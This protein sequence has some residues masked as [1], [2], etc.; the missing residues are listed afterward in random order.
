[1]NSIE[2]FGIAF[3]P[4]PDAMIDTNPMKLK[5]PWKDGYV[6]DFHSLKSTPTSDPYHPFN[7]E[8]TPMGELLYRLK[9][10][11]NLKAVA[12]TVEAAGDFVMNKWQPPVEVV[13]P[14][15]PSASR[16]VQ[17]VMTISRELGLALGLQVCEDAIEK[18]KTTSQMKNVAVWE[19]QEI[20]HDAIQAGI[21]TVDG[22]SVLLVDDLIESGTTLRR[23]TE[24][25]LSDCGAASVYVLVLT[26]TR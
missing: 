16:R 10:G 7:T 20:L 24:V 4:R 6:L 2:S 3:A 21:E 11:G 12:E 9:Y 8:R 22:R 5:G 25:L 23:T 14:A 13:V 15:P 17:P 18:T 19:R 1:M 26:R